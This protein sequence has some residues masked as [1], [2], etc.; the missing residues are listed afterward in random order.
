MT[1][2]F[3][4]EGPKE[5]SHFVAKITIHLIPQ[6][7]QEAG[8]SLVMTLR[9]GVPCKDGTSARRESDR[10]AMVSGSATGQA[11]KISEG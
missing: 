11:A 1:T 2:K 10:G 4:F 9:H 3:H 5:K 6:L 8:S 7:R